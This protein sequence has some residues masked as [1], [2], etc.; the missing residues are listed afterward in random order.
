MPRHLSIFLLPALLAVVSAT[1]AS[2]QIR[3]GLDVG[4]VIIRIAPEAPPPPRVEYRMVRP[5][6]RHIWIA[7]YWDRRDDRWDWAP[8]RWEEPSRRGSTW[9]R[10]QYRREGEAYR[11]EPGRWSYQR[12]EEGEDYSRW[13]KEHG[14]GRYKH[15][16]KDKHDKHD[17][18]GRDR[19]D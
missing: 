16:K 12:M 7:G 19:N 9:V 2:A 10:P 1:P 6:R 13:H 5:S 4:P 3:V 8:G 18:H 11:Y 14:N 15:Y 17:K